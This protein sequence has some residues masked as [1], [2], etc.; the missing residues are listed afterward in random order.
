MLA[1]ILSVR[2][3]AKD[4]S[5]EMST[6]NRRRFVRFLAIGVLN[7][8]FGFAVYA[9]LLD[10]RLHYTLAAAISTVLGV[11]F[12]F[13]TTGRLVFRRLRVASLPR[14][15]GVYALLYLMN[16]VGISLLEQ[17]GASNLLGGF[18]MLVPTAVLGYL[19][20]ARFVFGGEAP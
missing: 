7:T 6:T 13:L 2:P 16:V 18:L 11:L 10:G 17:A 19:L 15:V 9:V 1:S 14:F 8:A 20:N 5:T 4:D 3:E 12:N